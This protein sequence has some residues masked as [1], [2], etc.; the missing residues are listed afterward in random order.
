VTISTGQYERSHTS[1][2]EGPPGI[3]GSGLGYGPEARILEP[4]SAMT[5]EVHCELDASKRVTSINPAGQ[6]AFGGSRGEIVG[7][8][9]LKFVSELD[10]AVV[11]QWLDRARP[12]HVSTLDFR[13]VAMGSARQ[14]VFL[15][16]SDVSLGTRY[17]VGKPSGG[18][19]SSHSV[20]E[21]QPSR[22]IPGFPEAS[23][24]WITF[25]EQMRVKAMSDAAARL[26]GVNKDALVGKSLS[27]RQ[28]DGEGLF[29]HARI[30]RLLEE[31]DGGSAFY[32][33]STG[34]HYYQRVVSAPHSLTVTLEELDGRTGAAQASALEPMVSGLAQAISQVAAPISEESVSRYL[35][36][37]AEAIDADTVLIYEN[38]VRPGGRT[39]CHRRWAWTDDAR[40][41]RGDL[42]DGFVQY[43]IMMPGWLE[44]FIAGD[45]LYGRTEEISGYTRTFVRRWRIGA[46]LVVPV[47][48]D[49]LWGFV[50]FGDKRPEREWLPAQI[51][52]AQVAGFGFGRAIVQEAGHKRRDSGEQVFRK[53]VEGIPEIVF[54]IDSKGRWAFLNPAWERTIGYT[55]SSSIG[56]PVG[57]FI[58][59]EDR[60]RWDQFLAS[61]PGQ[62][63]EASSGVVRF[64]AD[65]GGTRWME[66]RAFREENNGD[67]H[68]F[69][70]LKDVTEYRDY[71]SGLIAAKEEAEESARIKSTFLASLSHEIRTPLAGILGYA[72]ILAEEVPEP[73]KEF[74]SSIEQNGRRLLETLN[75]VLDLA[76]LEAEQVRFTP[77]FMDLGMEVREVVYGL[78]P[79]AT[80]KSL[81]LEVRVPRDPLYAFI[82][83]ASL[84]RIVN[85]LVGNAI[86]YTEEG[87]VVV[88]IREA[89]PRHGADAFIL[90][91]SDS[92]IG[93]DRDFLPFIFDEFRQA[94]SAIGSTHNGAGLGLSITRRLVGMLGGTIEVDSEFGKGTVFTVTLPLSTEIPA[95]ETPGG[96]G[97]DGA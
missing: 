19:F 31:S 59:E 51:S 2:L 43:D 20:R 60:A 1:G 86:K 42:G 48:T 25:D 17:L 96:S 57:V 12:G 30:Q 18:P 16:Y 90:R 49:A 56:K 58:F 23:G 15:L 44:R 35:R 11:S 34:G 10:R 79:L 77:Q 71:Q 68:I 53:F 85:N 82:D 26:L 9:F 22:E 13:I 65:H 45:V 93:I 66:V 64:L 63:N 95:G 14:F 37:M 27:E 73:L 72:A 74:A 29:S 21:E 39:G 61:I 62:A 40:P 33:A 70:M 83:R 7:E 91:V 5:S 50:V 46:F 55:V 81:N 6:R 52:T 84:S 75:S 3:G 87:G 24:I 54:R 67:T 36:E 92:G 89:P 78:M 69:G 32:H 38:E 41:L 97:G 94:S 4:F 8:P 88:D 76:K 28:T 47:I 80:Q